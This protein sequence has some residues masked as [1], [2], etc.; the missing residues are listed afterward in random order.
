VRM[1]RTGA[2]ATISADELGLSC[3]LILCKRFGLRLGEAVG[4]TVADWISSNGAIVLLVRPN[5]IRKLKTLNS[6]RQV[7]LIG[8]LNSNE[9]AVVNELTRRSLLSP[10]DN[11]L[12]ALI[13]DVTPNNFISLR[14]RIGSELRSLL[15]QVTCNPNSVLHFLRHS[16]ASDVLHILRSD[17]DDLNSPISGA[18]TD[19]TRRLLLARDVA[20]RRALWAVCRLLGHKSP[21][22]TARCYVHGLE[23]WI[24]SPAPNGNWDG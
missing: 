7:P 15:K 1:A 6:Q 2:V 12:G 22:V 24:P 10:S 23:N 4:I 3:T 16:F 14:D 19:S 11:P 17:F 9:L 13:A 20:D 18:S 21:G 8:T 5:A